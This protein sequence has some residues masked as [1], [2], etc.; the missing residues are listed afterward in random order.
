MTHQDKCRY[1]ERRELEAEIARLKKRIELQSSYCDRKHSFC[2]DCRDKLPDNFCWR[3]EAQKLSHRYYELLYAVQN[4]YP[5]ETRHQT[6]LRI[7]MERG[8]GT[9][10]EGQAGAAL[11]EG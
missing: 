11:R 9:S 8:C 10:Q 3:C 7:I 2:P 6:A 4:K 1:A 5:G